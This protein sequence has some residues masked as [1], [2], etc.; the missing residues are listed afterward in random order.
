MLKSDVSLF[1]RLY[2]ANQL[3]DGDP[4]IFFSHENQLYPPLLSE[5]GTIRT[6]NKS[7]IIGCINPQI[8]S[9]AD[10]VDCKIF[11]SVALLHILAPSD[12]PTFN[13]YARKKF[14]PYVNNALSDVHRIDIV[15]DQ[16][17]AT[18]ITESTRVKRGEGV[19]KKVNLTTKN[20]NELERFFM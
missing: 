17:F 1:G 3:R 12:V 9:Q 8:F 14:L 6:K 2:I 4:T 16:Y 5:D 7:D 11:D 15:W 20:T 10:N 18:S 13:D 19:G